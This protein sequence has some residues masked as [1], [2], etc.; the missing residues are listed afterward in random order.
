MRPARW[1]KRMRIL[2]I[3]RD[4]PSV[5]RDRF[6]AELSALEARRAWDLHQEGT[7]REL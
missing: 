4:I 5:T 3:E 1:R 7:I 6:T 2:A